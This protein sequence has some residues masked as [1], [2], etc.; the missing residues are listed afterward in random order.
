M[1]KLSVGKNYNF[2]KIIFW[3]NFR[4]PKNNMFIQSYFKVLAA[5]Q[6]CQFDFLQSFILHL[7]HFIFTIKLLLK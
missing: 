3:L 5:Q 1:N 6:M 4:Y 2:I 7:N